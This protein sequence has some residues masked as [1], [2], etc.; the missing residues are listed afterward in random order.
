MPRGRRDA[1]GGYKSQLPDDDIAPDVVDPDPCKS[2]AQVAQLPGIVVGKT[3]AKQL[4]VGL[5][6]CVQ[7]TSPTIGLSFGASGARRPIAKQFRVIAVFEAGFDQYDSK[8]VYTDLYEAQAFYEQ[9]D[10]VT[11]VEM[12]V[13]DIDHAHAIASRS[14]RSSTT[15]STTRWTGRSSTTASSRRSSSSRSA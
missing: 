6:D 3:L 9:G 14:T 11:G 5:G 7:V 4:G 13:D 2:P 15:A 10:S 8:L 12:K 1:H